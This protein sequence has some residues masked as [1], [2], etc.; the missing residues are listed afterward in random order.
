MPPFLATIPSYSSKEIWKAVKERFTSSQS[1]NRA[2]I[3]ND[4][5]YLTFKEDAVNSFITEV[6]VSIKKMI[7]VG[8]DLPQD[9]LAYLVLFKFP[10]SLQL[11]K[12]QIMHSDKDLKVEF[13]LWTVQSCSLLGEK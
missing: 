5:L 8:I 11:L 4:F 3:F 13:T 1:S 6:Q 10:A 2:R 12:R 9:L 7:D